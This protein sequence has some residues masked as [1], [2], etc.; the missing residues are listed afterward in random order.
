MKFILSALPTA[1][2]TAAVMSVPVMT[3]ASTD[4]D[5]IEVSDDVT[6]VAVTQIIDADS[7]TDN[8][9]PAVAPFHTVPNSNKAKSQAL[10]TLVD[11]ITHKTVDNSYALDVSSF[12]S[13]EQA[14]KL[15]VQVSPKIAANQAAIA[16]SEYQT[17]ALRTIDN[18]LVFA[19]VSASA[20]HL[21]EDIDLSSLR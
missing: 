18:P 16:A 17:D 2:M 9:K 10:S 5:S 12:L 14:Q 15:L 7:P 11:P 6:P 4:A 13:L 21:D 8:D 19:R 1:M 3:Y 20:Y